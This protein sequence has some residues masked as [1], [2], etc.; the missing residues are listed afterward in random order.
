MKRAKLIFMGLLF[1]IFIPNVYALSYD[2]EMSVDNTNVKVGATK[3][4]KVSLKNIQGT[5]DGIFVCSLNVSSSE[6]IV[7]DSFRTFNNWSLTSGDLYLFDTG[8]PAKNDT[9]LFVIPVKINGEG[10]V[11]IK[12]ILCSDSVDEVA[13]E[14]KKINFTIKKEKPPVVNNTDNNI[15]DKDEEEEKKSSN[16]NIASIELSE[17]SLEFDPNITEYYV[18]V[19]K[20]DD[21]TVNPTLESSTASYVIDRNLGGDGNNIVITVTAEDGSEKIYTIYVE[22]KIKNF[23]EEKKNNNYTIIFIVIIGVLLLL[24]IYRIMRNKK[25]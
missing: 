24:N 7:L 25:K 2:M 22:E 9:D 23:V 20:F 3:E 14:N 8:N 5:D 13:I 19:D 1:S 12:N 21:F 15:N 11:E 16:C 6:N 10:Y 18:S 17:G 4:I